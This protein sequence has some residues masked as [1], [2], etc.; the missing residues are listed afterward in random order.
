MVTD[1]LAMGKPLGLGRGSASV[2]NTQ[3]LLRQ[4]TTEISAVHFCRS[5]AIQ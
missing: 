4:Q 3:T 1:P 5:R 2:N